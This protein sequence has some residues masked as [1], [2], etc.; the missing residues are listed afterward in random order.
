M[1]L[2]DVQAHVLIEIAPDFPGTAQV[3]TE[4]ITQRSPGAPNRRRIC[5]SY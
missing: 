1:V 2:T 4:S 3:R 5:P